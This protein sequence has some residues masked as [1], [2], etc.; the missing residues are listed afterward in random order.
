MYIK[1][2]NTVLPC[3]L[4]QVCNCNIWI[5][6][7]YTFSGILCLENYLVSRQYTQVFTLVYM[8]RHMDLQNL[9][10]WRV[11]ILIC[12]SILFRSFWE[13]F[14]KLILMNYLYICTSIYRTGV[15][16][17]VWNSHILV[18]TCVYLFSG[19]LNVL[20]MKSK[21]GFFVYFYVMVFLKSS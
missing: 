8:C 20:S 19:K 11:F 18:H 15:L 17:F 10:S 5:V 14:Y 4:L 7:I 1:L 12:S 16:I 3:K 13:S 6:Q 2:E 21:N 9:M